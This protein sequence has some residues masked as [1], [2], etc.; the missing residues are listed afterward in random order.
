MAIPTGCFSTGDHGAPATGGYASA[1]SPSLARA[2]SEGSGQRGQEVVSLIVR[3]ERM[4]RTQM[5]HAQ[6]IGLMKAIE[7]QILHSSAGIAKPVAPPRRPDEKVS[8]LTMEQRLYCLSVKNL[9]AALEDLDRSPEAF[10]DA[11]LVQRWWLVR[12]LFGFFTRA[13]DYCVRW[14]RPW[15]PHLWEQMHETFHYL[16]VR[17]DVRLGG[18]AAH[19]TGGFHPEHEYKRLLLLGMLH[20]L[21]PVRDRVAVL[22]AALDVWAER[23]GL[24]RAGGYIGAFGLFVVEISRDRPPREQ[25]SALEAGFNGW[26]LDPAP[27]FLDFLASLRT[28]ATA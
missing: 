17:E 23:T 19:G 3:L 28:E 7:P 22:E 24:H 18:G 2:S 16:V 4:A 14:D 15:P 5:P 1:L 9:K 21:V 8:A 20:G 11:A 27:A 12:H 25:Q 13:V 6:R 26:V 10:S